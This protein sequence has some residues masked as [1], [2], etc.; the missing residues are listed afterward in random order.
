MRAAVFPSAGCGSQGPVV[1]WPQGPAPRGSGTHSWCSDI[2][3][4]Y[5]QKCCLQAK[6]ALEKGGR[7]R[8]A[9]F[10]EGL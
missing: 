5:P 3:P 8:Q 2:I 4:A 7:A 10:T 9:G 1:S 6:T